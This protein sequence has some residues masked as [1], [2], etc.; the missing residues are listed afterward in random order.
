MP[1]TTKP[2]SSQALELPV[3]FPCLARSALCCQS[4][5]AALPYATLR[6]ARRESASATGRNKRRQAQRRDRASA[7]PSLPRCSAC[8]VHSIRRRPRKCRTT[9]ELP[10]ADRPSS[11]RPQSLLLCHH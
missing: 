7:S 2:S 6:V 9:S 5:T 4:R 10:F 8:P 11:E 3:Y 1:P